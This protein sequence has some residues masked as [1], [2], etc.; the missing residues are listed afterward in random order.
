MYMI[1]KKLSVEYVID[2]TRSVGVVTTLSDDVAVK[3]PAVAVT[4]P[5]PVTDAVKVVGLP[6]VGEKLPSAG[7][8]DQLGLTGTTLP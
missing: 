2:A 4:V 7:E 8:T 3:A 6:A 5:L 1:P